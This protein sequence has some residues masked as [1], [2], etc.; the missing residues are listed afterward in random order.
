M[1]RSPAVPPGLNSRGSISPRSNIQAC[2][3]A[4]GKADPAQLTALDLYQYAMSQEK[5]G[6]GEDAYMKTYSAAAA[7]FGSSAQKEALLARAKYGRYC[8]KKKNFAEA[9]AQLQPVYAADP[10]GRVVKDVSFL[11]ADALVGM[12]NRARA[13]PYLEMSLR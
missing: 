10:Q 12:G 1:R 7:K 13:I 8:L 3:E 5:S 6:A 4:Y 11:I 9:F 2:S